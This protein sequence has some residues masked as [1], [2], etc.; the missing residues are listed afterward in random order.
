MRGRRKWCALLLAILKL[1]DREFT[2]RDITLMLSPNLDVCPPMRLKTLAEMG[3]LE[4]RKQQ[5]QLNVYRVRDL[6]RLREFY[7]EI[8]SS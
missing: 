2:S 4:C 8:S 3:I 5:G 7:I 6:E 1:K